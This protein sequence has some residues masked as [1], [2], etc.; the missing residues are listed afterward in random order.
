MDNGVQLNVGITTNNDR[1][2]E[3]VKYNHSE[4]FKDISKAAEQ[5]HADAQNSLAIM[6]REGVAIPRSDYQAFEWFAKA[7]E[8]GHADAQNNLAIM[9][10]D[11]K[12]IPE[13]M[14]MVQHD[15]D[16]NGD[17]PTLQEYKDLFIDFG[18]DYPSNLELS[19]IPEL[20]SKQQGIDS[21]KAVD[22]FIKAV[23]NGSDAAKVNLKNMFSN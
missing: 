17:T 15:F 4:I 22:W 1:G 20:L 9:Y 16:I 6:Y 13:V 2:M 11:G 8:Q 7:A 23:A 21:D 10:R 14:Y 3:T 12:E 19:E 18:I 5:G